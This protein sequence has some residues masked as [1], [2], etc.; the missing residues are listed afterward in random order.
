MPVKKQY[1]KGAGNLWVAPNKALSY[2]EKYFSEC[3][4]KLGIDFQNN[5]Y[6]KPC[7]CLDFLFGNNSY[8]EVDGEQHYRDKSAI[9]K[10]ELRNKLLEKEGYKLVGRCRW[11]AFSKLNQEEKQKYINQLILSILNGKS[12]DSLNKM[13][14]NRLDTEASE[15][16]KLEQKRKVLAALKKEELD[17][18]I[19][20]L[21]NNVKE[22]GVTEC[23]KR[24]GISHTQVRR[25]CLKN[26]IELPE[27][28]KTKPYKSKDAVNI[29]ENLYL[30][31]NLNVKKCYAIDKEYNVYT[32]NCFNRN[33]IKKIKTYSLRKSNKKFVVL[34]GVSNKKIRVFL[35]EIVI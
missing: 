14:K 34:Q 12:I 20:F 3:F 7:Y 2:P 4:K 11:K 30:I 31:K 24:L 10:D 13:L 5:V 29:P 1:Q 9:E 19:I 16:K 6:V 23:S 21:K 26:N 32:L 17:E 8:F 22:L 28:G 35:D 27:R 15:I 33:K 18:R 25:F